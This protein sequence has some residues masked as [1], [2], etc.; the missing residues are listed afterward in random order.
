MEE[1]YPSIFLIREEGSL[2]V[3]KPPENIYVLA[4][5]NGLIFDAGYGTIKTIKYV[6]SQINKI[7]RKYQEE[8][9][10]CNIKRVIPSHVH[11][12]H[13]SGLKRLRRYLGL[14]I[15]LTEKMATIIRDKKSYLEYY[16]SENILEEAYEAK[17]IRARLNSYLR[18]ITTHVFF[19]NIYG[20]SFITQPDEIINSTTTISINGEELKIF[21]SPG[22]ASDH[23]SLYNEDKGILFS[24]DNVLRT[25]TTWL[26]P[27]TSNIEHYLETI[28]TFQELPNLNLILPAHGSPIPDPRQRLKEILAHRHQRTQQVL[29]LIQGNAQKGITLSGLLE[30]L[31]P[32]QSNFMHGVARGWIILTLR[33]LRSQG[34]IEYRLEG[35]LL[36]FYPR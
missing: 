2:G 6:V 28:R 12:D 27:P 10:P 33:L 22:H 26:G 23:I 24:G 4:G 29:A 11:P 36:R 30:A 5:K 9:L 7:K 15:V 18:K 34:Q 14:K 20:L 13:F 8:G 1:V 17:S 19:K 16:D 31:Y 21:P 32:N 25:I 35:N 3:M